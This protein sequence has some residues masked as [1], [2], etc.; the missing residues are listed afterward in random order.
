MRKTRTLAAV[1]AVAA[2][3]SVSAGTASAATTTQLV[4]GTTLSTLA[5]AAT[6]VALN[7]L[8]QPGQTATNTV[9]GTVTVTSTGGWTLTAADAAN[10]GHLVSAGGPL[11][12]PATGPQSEAQT[13][14][15]IHVT[16]AGT[17]GGTTGSTGVAVSNLAPTIAT[18]T[19]ADTLSQTFTLAL[20]STESLLTGCVYSTTIT[21]TAS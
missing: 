3:A 2:L 19:L 4:S 20:G 8:F 17:L 14:N 13:V 11:C 7:S 5:L 1:L 10:N 16:T 21:Y 18:G 9:P 6:P 12:S 15:Q